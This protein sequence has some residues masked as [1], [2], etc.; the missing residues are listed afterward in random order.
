[1]RPRL[2][3]SPSR[4][5]LLFSVDPA[6]KHV[7][8]RGTCFRCPV[9]CFR[10]NYSLS[11]N[12][13]FYAV[14]AAWVWEAAC[15][16]RRGRF[17]C[18]GIQSGRVG[19]RHVSSTDINTALGVKLRPRCGLPAH[20]FRL[21]TGPDGCL[22]PPSQFVGSRPGWSKFES[23]GACFTSAFARCSCSERFRGPTVVATVAPRKLSR[24]LA[25]LFQRHFVAAPMGRLRQ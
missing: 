10:V 5:H 22:F 21:T 12:R 1:M 2:S 20:T 4:W 14:V 8:P 15:S 24:C 16:R 23:I 3:F 18:L 19:R 11:G 17:W 6:A 7:A 25:R 13:T 9:S